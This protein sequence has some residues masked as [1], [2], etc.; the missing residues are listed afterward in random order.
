MAIIDIIKY[1]GNIPVYKHPKEDYN[2]GAQL[3]V[4]ETQEAYIMKDGKLFGPYY[5]GKYTLNTENIPG[6]RGIVELV[7]NGVSPN[8]YE[9]Y[10]INK[11]V[12]LNLL[13]GSPCP[14]PIKDPE[15]H[16]PFNIQCHGTMGLRVSDSKKVLK[17]VVGTSNAFSNSAIEDCF[18]GLMISKIKEDITNCIN[19][20]GVSYTEITG[21]LEY[22]SK[23]LKASLSELLSNYGLSVQEFAV[24][25]IQIIQDGAFDQVRTSMVKAAGRDI[26]GI[27]VV[28][29]RFLNV[30]E[31]MAKNPSGN[32]VMDILTSICTGIAMFPSFREIG[33]NLGERMNKKK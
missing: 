25:D 19:E 2:R 28:T 9:I 21:K 30:M 12:S 6:I 4:H 24:E 13:W 16:I 15:L 3:I 20:D 27:D 29:D 22:L 8:H 11:T 14:W 17:E 1:E 31:E 7:T 5:K 32:Q 10:F 23:R 26:E 33:Q 18:R